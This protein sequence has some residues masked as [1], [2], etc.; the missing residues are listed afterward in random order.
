[1]PDSFTG[2]TLTC[3]RGERVVFSALSFALADGD[4]LMLR[5]P[6]GSGKSS[7][8]RVMAGLS[9]AVA[10][11][12][13]WNGETVTDDI[14]GHHGRLIYAGHQNALKPALT[15]R[16]NLLFWA[17]MHGGGSRVDAA[18]E[19]IG[20]SALADVPARFL[21]AGEARRVCLARLAAIEAPLWL[22]D[23][24]ATALDSQAQQIVFELIAEHREQG[25]MVAMSAH[26]GPPLP[27]EK[28]LDIAAFAVARGAAEGAFE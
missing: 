14:T 26:G 28:L 24:P 11:A 22:L 20:L 27:D 23:E 1:M 13:R 5:G 15:V 16:E 9:P 10:G 19:R 4:A 6:N 7:L 21:S 12:V 2:D 3:I 25:G 18:L 17:E 8:L